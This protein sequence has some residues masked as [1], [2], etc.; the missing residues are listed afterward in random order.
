[1]AHIDTVPAQAAEGEVLAMY[2]RQQQFWGYVPNYA[3]IFSPRPEVMAR[4]ASLLAGIRRPMD[5]RRFELVTLAAAEALGNS[6]CCLAHGSALRQFYPDD[7]VA[8]IAS[9]AATEALTPAE[10]EM[11]RFARKVARNAVAVTVADVDALR[12]HGFTDAEVF[13]IVATVA[14]RAFFTKLL[15]ALGAEP[16]AAWL[17][18]DGPLRDVLTVGRPIGQEPADRVAVPAEAA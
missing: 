9:G 13:D 4:W 17:A 1:M 7:A 8:E 12:R 3:K 15:D 18:M 16:D 14:G 5:P 11:L 2:E 6:Y 10:Q